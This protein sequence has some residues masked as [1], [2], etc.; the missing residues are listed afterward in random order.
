[1]AKNIKWEC[2]EDAFGGYSCT[3]KGDTG[4][5]RTLINLYTDGTVSIFGKEVKCKM[6]GKRGG[7]FAGGTIYFCETK[8]SKGKRRK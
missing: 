4:G 1:M 6:S 2:Q 3:V 8:H 7:A 5:A